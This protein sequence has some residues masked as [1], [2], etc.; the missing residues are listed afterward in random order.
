M[1]LDRNGVK[2]SIDVAEQTDEWLLAA[3]SEIAD[4]AK[5]RNL[6]IP[7][8]A[9]NVAIEGSAQESTSIEVEPLG[10]RE[11]ITL[12]L[13]YATKAYWRVGEQ[14]NDSRDSSERLRIANEETLAAE[15]ETWLTDEKVAFVASAQEA[16]PE[17]RFT[18]VATPNTLAS[19]K[20]I[21]AVAKTFGKD[22]PYSTYVWDELYARY[23]P[24]ELSGTNP[25]SGS[26]VVFSLIPSKVDPELYGTVKEQQ[27]KLAELQKA[28]PDLKV[29][30][31]LEAVTYWQTLRAG[32][33]RLADSTT[34]DTTYIR[35][36][37]LPTK[38]VG[39]WRCLPGSC[40]G[41]VGGARLSYSSAGDDYN[42]RVSVG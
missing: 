36:F 6:T 31:V 33:N 42:G 1:E 32:G 7:S 30:S 11:A 2:V 29:P 40:V 4:E 34:F 22:Q 13:P 20:E 15:L 10:T 5:E 25:E 24:E 12:Q 41:S 28:N 8:L 37:D 16:D 21:T 17:L 18:L 39:G 26:N 27:T 35:H 9:G 14:L 38:R 19:N 23:T 3:V